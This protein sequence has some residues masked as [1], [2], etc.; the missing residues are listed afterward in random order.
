VVNAPRAGE[1]LA[2]SAPLGRG[3]AVAS[4]ACQLGG[5]AIRCPMWLPGE[6]GCD[7]L[8]RRI[9]EAVDEADEDR[10]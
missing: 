2:R 5:I 4:R 8:V 6:V 10:K 7:A 3:V 1:L 9:D